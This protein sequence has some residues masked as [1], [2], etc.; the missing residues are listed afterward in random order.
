MKNK[1]KK[2]MKKN[3]AK[4]NSVRTWYI[5]RNTAYCWCHLELNYTR[6]PS[7]YVHKTLQS[8][9]FIDLGKLP[10]GAVFNK[11]TSPFVEHLLSARL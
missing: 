5:K 7:E 10:L 6:N 8:L 3:D 9:H 4:V 1:K 2:K 11:R